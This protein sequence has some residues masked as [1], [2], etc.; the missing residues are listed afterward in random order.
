M[1]NRFVE[2]L[3]VVAS[4]TVSPAALMMA[5]RVFAQAAGKCRHEHSSAGAG[6]PWF[7]LGEKGRW[8]YDK[9][10]PVVL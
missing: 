3:G 5:E 10:S 9:A 7:I 8:V 6:C 1:R 4:C 2:E